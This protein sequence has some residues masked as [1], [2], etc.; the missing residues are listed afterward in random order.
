MPEEGLRIY[1]SGKVRL[2]DYGTAAFVGDHILYYLIRT[3][4]KFR[5]DLFFYLLESVLF[6]Y[7]FLM[8]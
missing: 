5:S 1:Y 4:A 3:L 2:T 8:D 6:L 7:P